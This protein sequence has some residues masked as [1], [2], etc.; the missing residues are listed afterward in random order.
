GRKLAGG[1]PQQVAGQGPTVL[2]VPVPTALPKG[3]YTVSWKTISAVDGHLATGSFSFGVGQAPTG[4]AQSSAAV[5]SPGPSEVAVVARWVYLSGLIGLLGLAF[6]ELVVLWRGPPRR[7]GP[8]VVLAG[9]LALAGAVG[10]PPA[11]RAG[12]H[13]P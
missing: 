7:L 9:A 5:K 10:F 6:N 11:R 3:V 2:R 8:A 13:L 1:S 12:G 4:A